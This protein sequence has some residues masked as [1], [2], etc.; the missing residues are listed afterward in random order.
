MP[1]YPE[2]RFRLTPQTRELLFILSKKYQ[3]SKSEMMRKLIQEKADE[4]ELSQSAIDN[5]KKMEI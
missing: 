5:I 3:C 1:G 2:T 4:E